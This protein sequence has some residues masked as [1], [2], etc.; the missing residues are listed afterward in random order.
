MF[1]PL[2]KVAKQFDLIMVAAW[3][4]FK[5]HH[6]LFRALRQL[7]HRG[8]PIQVALAGYSTTTNSE[9]ILELADYY[10][11]R[12]CLTLF[13]KVPPSQV[14][15]LFRQSRLNL[16]WSR[17]EGNNRAIIEGMFCD[18]PVIVRAGHNYGDHY[19][20]I[21]DKTGCFA[22]E[23]ELADTILAMLEQV[24]SFDPRAFVREWLSCE[25][26]TDVLAGV[27]A[28]HDSNWKGELAIKVN[29]L[30]GMRYADPQASAHFEADYRFL[31]STIRRFGED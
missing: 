17:F 8:R 2:P 18:V 14:A 22:N 9:R 20:Y 3:D 1:Q 26:A 16:L 28:E 5:R 15:D 7:A 23:A 25:R 27:I 30:D 10:D 13:D 24:G 21:N 6:A 4:P 11:V 31:T 12:S 29:E 19:F